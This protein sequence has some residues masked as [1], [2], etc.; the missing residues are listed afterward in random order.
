MIH[1]LALATRHFAKAHAFYTDAMGFTLVKAV[2]R[3]APGGGWTKHVFYDMGDGSLFALWDLQGLSPDQFARE[4]WSAGLSSG[5]G[6]PAWINHVA[7]EAADEP[8]LQRRR[9]RWLDNGFHVTDVDHDFIKST[10]TIDPDG[11]MVEWTF[12]TRALNAEDAAEARAI[13]EDDTPATEAD[14]EVAVTRSPVKK[15]GVLAA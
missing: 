9:Q 1:H 8:D 13:L 14:Y 2:K 7:F 15:K 11:T 12:R 4:D 6:L 5:M 3:Q 10:Y